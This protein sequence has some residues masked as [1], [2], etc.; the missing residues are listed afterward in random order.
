M[1]INLFAPVDNHIQEPFLSRPAQRLQQEGLFLQV[2]DAQLPRFRPDVN[3]IGLGVLLDLEGHDLALGILYVQEFNEL[4]GVVLEDADVLVNFT[5]F[6]DFEHHALADVVLQQRVCLMAD[7]A[8][9][10]LAQFAERIAGI[11]DQ[12]STAGFLKL[13]EQHIDDL[14][15]RIGGCAEE[16]ARAARQPAKHVGMKR[17]ANIPVTLFSSPR[18]ELVGIAIYGLHALVLGSVQHITGLDVPLVLKR[19]GVGQLEPG[20]FQAHDAPDQLAIFPFDGD[21][22][23]DEILQATIFDPGADIRPDQRDQEDQ[24]DGDEERPVDFHR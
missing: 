8:D 15:E 24:S 20:R 13:A 16:V 10:L 5:G 9:V 1:Q 23:A 17:A 11:V 21:V 2:L 3:P 6:G 12:K 4:R 19:V 14:L 18:R 7:L 22:K